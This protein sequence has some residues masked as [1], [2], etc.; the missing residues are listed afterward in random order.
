MQRRTN[1]G[2]LRL[3]CR[4]TYPYLC[5]E[6]IKLVGVMDWVG[7]RHGQLDIPTLVADFALVPNRSTRTFCW[8]SR[9]AR[10]FAALHLVITLHMR[11]E[12]GAAGLLQVKNTLG[13]TPSG[14]L[15]AASAVEGA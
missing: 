9:E 1:A 8:C 4:N 14:S 7:Y 6:T 13:S 5:K 11:Q 12:S 10:Y 2:H 15:I 3:E